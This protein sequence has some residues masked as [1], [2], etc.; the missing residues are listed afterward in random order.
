M[1]SV[2]MS[3]I[4]YFFKLKSLVLRL[5]KFHM[6]DYKCSS[7]LTCPLVNFFEFLKYTLLEIYYKPQHYQVLFGFIAP[8]N[9]A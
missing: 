2:C 8:M 1:M 3:T 6:Y 7:V 4:K 9:Y 5:K